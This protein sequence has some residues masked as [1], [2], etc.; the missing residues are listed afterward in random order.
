M[1]DE[2]TFYHGTRRGFVV[3]GFVT[4]RSFHGGDGTFAP[5]VEGKESPPDAHRYV[6]ATTDLHLAWAYAWAAPGRGKPKVLTIR[7]GGPVEPDP[8]HGLT[9]PAFRIDGF[10]RVLRID[11]E[12]IMSEFEATSGWAPW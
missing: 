12:P 7:P 10:C 4:P 8:E 11:R 9:M 5:M 6:F 2:P 1:T 3:G